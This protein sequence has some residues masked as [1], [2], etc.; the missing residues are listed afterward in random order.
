[1]T[2]SY[3]SANRAIASSLVFAEPP[4]VKAPD[5]LGKARAIADAAIV[6]LA[7][8]GAPIELPPDYSEPVTES[9]PALSNGSGTDV[10]VG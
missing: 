10:F 6:A 3:R 8:I 1:M 5:A 4:L 9:E 7:E 2:I